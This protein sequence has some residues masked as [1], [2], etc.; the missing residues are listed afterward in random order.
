MDR[1]TGM[2]VFVRAVADGSLSA[3]A[4]E[5]GM[6]AAVATK[7]LDALEAHLDVKLLH[8]TTRRLTLTEAGSEYLDAYMR[9]I[10]RIGAP[11]PRYVRCWII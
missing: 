10:R 1:L 11:Q 8:R 9:S 5:L 2:Q 4:R 3:A 7:H 6:S